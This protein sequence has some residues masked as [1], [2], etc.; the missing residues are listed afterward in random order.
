MCTVNIGIGHDNDLVITEF[1]DI[2][3]IMD[4]CTKCSD[5]SL[6]LCIAV[7]SVKTGFFYIENF[8]SKR[9]YSLCRTVSCS[10]CRTARGISL[11][12]VNLTVFRVFIGTVC[13]FARQCHSIES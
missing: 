8:A 12:D 3:V 11:Y 6:D 1:T 2:K 7:N 13:K 4:T 9:K 10:L 5:H